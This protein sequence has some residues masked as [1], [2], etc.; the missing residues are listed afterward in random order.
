MHVDYNG[1]EMV[2]CEHTL[3][4]TANSQHLFHMLHTAGPRYAA[5]RL[6]LLGV[7]SEMSAF[8]LLAWVRVHAVCDWTRCNHKS[9]TARL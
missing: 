9:L 8:T 2:M 3:S 7:A 1:H 6:L 4:C 5:T